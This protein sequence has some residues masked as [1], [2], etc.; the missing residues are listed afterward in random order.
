MGASTAGE[1]LGLAT[2]ITLNRHASRIGPILL[3]V[4]GVLLLLDEARFIDF[5]LA[6]S[7]KLD[8][9]AS[10]RLMLKAVLVSPQFLFIT[11]AKEAEATLRRPV[12]APPATG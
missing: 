11:P 12:A 8:Y 3:M 5:D 2:C 4:L 6:R 7:N 9:P 1:T 10:L